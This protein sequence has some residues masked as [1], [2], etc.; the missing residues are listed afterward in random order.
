M[1]KLLVADFDGSIVDYTETLSSQNIIAIRKLREK[2]I[3]FTIATGRRWS[4]IESKIRILNINIPVILY[5]GAGIYHPVESRFLFIK[6]LSN[7][8]VKDSLQFI[9][10]YYEKIKVGVYY[11]DML[12][13]DEEALLLLERENEKI[14]KIFLEGKEE[15]LKIIK[16][17]ID[18][19]Y[20]NKINAVFSAPYYLEILPYGISKG[21]ALKMLIN[22]LN[23]SPKEVIAIGDFDNDEDMLKLAGLSFTLINS[24]E[25]LKKVAN[26]ILDCNP[27]DSLYRIGKK[28]INLK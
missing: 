5:N 4:S 28:I 3:D 21:N 2:G 6:Y 8:E 15:D 18:R 22:M 16:T 19:N 14:I 12:F 27:N 24:S 13:E 10:I 23:I 1:Y 26:F 7:R 11:E 9:K 20:N 25:K 17:H